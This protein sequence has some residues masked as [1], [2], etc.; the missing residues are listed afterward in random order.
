MFIY[1]YPPAIDTLVS[2]M[3]VVAVLLV[4]MEVVIVVGDGEYQDIILSHKVGE[5]TPKMMR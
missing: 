1:N 2:G 3:V 4:M 5:A